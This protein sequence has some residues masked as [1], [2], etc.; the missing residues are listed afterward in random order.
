MDYLSESIRFKAL[1]EPMRLRILDILGSSQVSART[2]L[3]A[4]NISQATLFRHLKVL[5]ECGL[6]ID[7]KEGPE[8]YYSIHA[9]RML[10]LQRC[11]DA[12]AGKKENVIQTINC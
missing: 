9:Q 12:W 6:V 1:S 7:R 10:E 8:R 11:L 4:L 5:T 2:L 3:D